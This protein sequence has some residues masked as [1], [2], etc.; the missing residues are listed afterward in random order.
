MALAPDALPTQ[1]RP[2]ELAYAL[3]ALG[4]AAMALGSRFALPHTSP[5]ARVTV[6]TRAQL[7]NLSPAG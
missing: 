6:L 3:D 5:W 2:S 7:L 4:A 1:D